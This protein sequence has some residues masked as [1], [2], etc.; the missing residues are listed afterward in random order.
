MRF[1]KKMESAHYFE[2]DDGTVVPAHELWGAFYDLEGTDV[3]N[4]CNI[5]SYRVEKF[6]D[7]QGAIRY[8]TGRSQYKTDK[9][10]ALIK[11]L[12]KLYD[13]ATFDDKELLNKM[14]DV[15]H[16]RWS[17]W[18]KYQFSQGVNNP[19]G[20][21]TMPAWAVER[22]SRQM[23]TAYCD[24]TQKEKDSDVVEAEISL[25]CIKEFFEKERQ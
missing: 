2:L 6:L 23:E 22:W 7:R 18:M 10:P 17:K 20:S 21:W 4:P 3:Y 1:F 8:T 11:K 25:N 13:K 9:L 19:D 15:E 5:C 12:E 24:L 16:A 14:A